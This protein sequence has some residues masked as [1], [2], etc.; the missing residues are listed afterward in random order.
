MLHGNVPAAVARLQPMGHFAGT[1]HLNLAIGLP[2]RNQ[3]TLSN[4]LH[5]I[6]DP[7][8]PNYR[9]YLTPEQ[10][11][12][13]F[14]P[15]EKDYEAVIA[16]AKANGLKVTTTH[17]N[18]VI[19]DVSGSVA[20]IEKALHVTLRV[21]QHPTEKRIFHAPDT[22]PSLDLTVPV[23]HISGL[24]NYVVP[25]PLL[26]N[27]GSSNRTTNP[28]Q[29]AVGSSPGGGYMGNDF[30]AAYVPGVTLTGAGQTVGLLQIRVRFLPERHHGVRE[31]AIICPTCL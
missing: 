10:F 3:A 12:E 26:H 9:H 23:L 30:R 19:L 7:A 25:R 6:Y 8:S 16:F 22:E 4:L 2:L 15:T 24:D 28:A 14:G 5:Q 13:Q 11:T 20:D 27:I 1:N 29:P 18:R 17:P 21:Y 31:P